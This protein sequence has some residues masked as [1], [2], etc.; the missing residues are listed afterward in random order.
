MAS[1]A[2]GN[3]VSPLTCFP[4]GFSLQ[5]GTQLAWSPGTS[6]KGVRGEVVALPMVKK[7]DEFKSWLKPW[8]SRSTPM[9]QPT[10]R[11]DVREEFATKESFEKMKRDAR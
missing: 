1:G 9:S 11:P 5:K 2:A 6:K 4:L 7:F 3:A 10:G 8:E